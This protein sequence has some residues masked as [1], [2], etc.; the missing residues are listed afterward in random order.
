M[1]IFS[2]NNHSDKKNSAGGFQKNPFLYFGAISFML[3]GMLFFGSSSLAQLDNAGIV[4]LGVRSENTAVA[5]DLYVTQ[6]SVQVLETPDLKITDSFVHG[7]ATPQAYSPQTLGVIFGEPAGADNHDDDHY[8]GLT[9]AVKEGDTIT[10]IAKTYKA[11][12]EEIIAFNGLKDQM[13]IF[14]GDVI[15]VPGGTMPKKAPVIVEAPVATSYFAIAATGIITQ[16]LHGPNNAVDVANSC[17]TSVNAAAGGV[18]QRAKY[19][20][21]GGG[22][23]FVTVKHANGVVTYYG[24]LSSI[25]VNAGDAV[26]Q[27]QRLGLMGT[28]GKSTGCHVHFGVTGARNP[29]AG[30]GLG[31]N[32]SYK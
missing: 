17:G 24:H 18:I 7:V 5:A 20:W 9:H 11:K 1:S 31:A 25:S 29:L 3:L 13:D 8:D 10:A 14:V 16:R 30:Y 28:T 32:V 23:N 21:N 22:G 4:T 2:G 6:Q 12:A 19:G 15:A 26:S 27:G